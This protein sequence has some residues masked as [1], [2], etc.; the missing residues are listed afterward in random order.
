MCLGAE[1][2]LLSVLAIP[3]STKESLA[4]NS[5]DGTRSCHGL[6]CILSC[7]RMERGDEEKGWM[8]QQKGRIT[9]PPK[10]GRGVSE[11]MSVC[12]ETKLFSF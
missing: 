6:L 12:H 1:R 2:V 3:T 5:G 7:P 10:L 11:Q 9:P 8:G 4:R